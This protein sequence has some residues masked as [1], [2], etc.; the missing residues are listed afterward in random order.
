MILSINI[1]V[2]LDPQRP[3]LF[4]TL[5]DNYLG[6]LIGATLGAVVGRLLWP[7]LPQNLLRG[8]LARYFEEL[9]A[10][11]RTPSAG[12]GTPLAGTMIL[13]SEAAQ[14]VEHMVFP[15]CPPIERGKLAQFVRTARPLTLELAAWREVSARIHA[16]DMSALL[17]TLVRDLERDIDGCLRQLSGGFQKRRANDSEPPDLIAC[18]ARVETAVDGILKPGEGK[19]RSQRERS[20]LLEFSYRCRHVT[21]RLVACRDQ[22]LGLRLAYYLSD[23]AL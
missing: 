5:L 8:N 6:L 9:R 3:V 1:G 7:L 17:H 11:P 16:G 20:D 14:A 15:G 2:A 23:T 10:S 21:K 12:G 22:F 19:V 13:V 4:G 18:L